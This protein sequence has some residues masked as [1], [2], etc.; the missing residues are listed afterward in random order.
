VVGGWVVG[1][2]DCC[3]CVVY[4]GEV[5]CGDSACVALVDHASASFLTFQQLSHV[6]D[7]AHVGCWHREHGTCRSLLS[8]SGVTYRAT[9]SAVAVSSSVGPFSPHSH[10][11]LLLLIVTL[12]LVLIVIGTLFYFIFCR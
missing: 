4:V 3:G 9:Y 10:W 1:V 6:A 7:S 5:L 11:I 2:Q 12:L 8:P